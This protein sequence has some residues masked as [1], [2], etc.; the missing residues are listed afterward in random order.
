MAGYESGLV[1][2]GPKFFADGTDQCG[3]ITA[4]Q[5]RT[6]DRTPEQ[7]ITNDCHLVLSAG[8]YHMTGDKDVRS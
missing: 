7:Y 3:T 4:R 2:E 5:V 8:K 1:T 6:A